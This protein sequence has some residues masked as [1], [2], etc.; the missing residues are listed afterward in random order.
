[1]GELGLRNFYSLF[2]GKSVLCLLIFCQ[3]DINGKS[4]VLNST[5]GTE[6]VMH[7]TRKCIAM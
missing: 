7:V 4:S 6:V 3:L 1:M 2:H 5:D